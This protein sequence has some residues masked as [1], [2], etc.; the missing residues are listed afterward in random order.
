MEKTPEIRSGFGQP[1][2][3]YLIPIV[4]AAMILVAF[5]LRIRFIDDV[6]HVGEVQYRSFLITRSMYFSLSDSIPA[7][8][9]EANANSLHNLS[10]WNL[11]VREPTITEVLTAAGYAILGREDTRI[12]RLLTIVY[13][14][15]GSL[16][17]Y[18]IARTWVVA[19][20][21]LLATAYFLFIPLG[22]ILSLSFQ[23][24]SLMIMMFMV[25]LFAIIQY[26]RE[27]TWRK[28]IIAAVLTAFALFVRPLVLFALSGAFLALT[29]QQGRG[30]RNWLDQKNLVFFGI[31]SIPIIFYYLYQIMVTQNLMQQA[32]VSFIPLLLFTRDYWRDWMLT[33]INAVGLGP[34]L[35]AAI[36]IPLANRRDHRAV[37]IGL[38]AGY[39]IFCLLF[40]Y[41][42][43]FAA[44]YHLQL[45][46]IVA[47]SFASLVSIIAVQIRTIKLAWY[48]LLLYVGAMLLLFYINYRA[49][50]HTITTSPGVESKE[51]A[52]EI[53]GLVQHS[54]RVVY[55][56]SY[57]GW[58][59]EY[60]GEMTG[61]YWRRSI[62]D[63]DSAFGF[64]RRA[65]VEERLERLWF[66][67]EY[68][69]ITDMQEYRTHHGD[70]RDYLEE[71]CRLLK[72][73]EEF[74]IYSSCDPIE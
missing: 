42:I 50:N 71:N 14:L 39:I 16:F 27:Q 48:G 72:E 63:L 60:Y 43:R 40:S 62:S 29:V 7:W 36:G 11:V 13:W 46:P 25:S 66:T 17:L 65:S 53:G 37:L 54:S 58:P 44:Y 56:A 41:H 47:L 55:I 26:S 21:A 69:V 30:I 57:Y 70:L 35:A 23:A 68:F 45:V 22:I 38:W 1:T 12:A 31:S 64:D 6:H 15:I 20:S 4:L 61:T 49:I 19:E 73:K 10:Y 2:K 59:L 67:P 18:R 74:I 9:R 32:E 3:S 28:L 51:V 5:I 33:T 24:D 34:L 8:Q 52:A